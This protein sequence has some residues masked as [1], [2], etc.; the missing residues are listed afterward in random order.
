VGEVNDAPIE[1]E[2]ELIAWADEMFEEYEIVSFPVLVDDLDDKPRP[3]VTN[4]PSLMPFNK[5]A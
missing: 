2:E 1:T 4:R 3:M 5:E